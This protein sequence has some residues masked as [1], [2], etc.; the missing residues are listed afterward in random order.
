MTIVIIV[1]GTYCAAGGPVITEQNQI[2]KRDACFIIVPST[3]IERV[4]VRLRPYIDL[5]NSRK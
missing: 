5:T 3:T 2:R 4:R 1:L